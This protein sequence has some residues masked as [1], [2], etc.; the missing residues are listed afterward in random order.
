ME[1]ELPCSVYHWGVK[2]ARPIDRVMN[3]TCF[4]KQMQNQETTA[5]KSC[6]KLENVL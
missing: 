1:I 4:I 5:E 6:H 2:T 3:E